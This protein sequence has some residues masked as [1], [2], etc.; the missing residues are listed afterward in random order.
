MALS[1]F[2]DRSRAPRE[3]EVEEALGRSYSLWLALKEHV[4]ETHAPITEKWGYSGASY[5]WGLQLKGKKRAVL[6]M[7]PCKKHFLASFALGEKAVAAAKRAGLPDP[8]IE[9]I[10]AAPRYAEGRGVRIPVRNKL[11]LA[12]VQQLAAIKMG[13]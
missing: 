6:Y 12:A 11:T 2:D 10:D 7:T 1:T 5:G 3:R 8:V 13:T 9:V 4:A